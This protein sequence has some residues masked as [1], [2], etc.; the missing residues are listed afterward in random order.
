MSRKKYNRT[1]DVLVVATMS[2]GKT[3]LVN[4]LIGRELLHVANE[5]TTACH[6]RIENRHDA[7]YITGC[8]YS[9]E[10]RLL[11]RQHDVSAIQLREWNSYDEI[12]RISLVGR[13][14][15]DGKLMPGLVLHD[16]PGVN[17]SQDTLHAELTLETI[18][19]VPFKLLVYVINA[20]QLG[21]QDDRNLLEK[22]RAE[23]VERQDST[24]CF[25]L[26][27]I[28]LLD[29]GK[30]ET[31][32]KYVANAR[33]YLVNMGFK[34]PIII[35][36]MASVALYARKALIGESLTRAQD[37]RLQQALDG[38]PTY[39]NS[40]LSYTNIPRCIVKKVSL[41]LRR[42]EKECGRSQLRQRS[43]LENKLQQLLI[44]SGLG[45]LREYIFYMQSKGV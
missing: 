2:A 39:S 16:T 19:K 38:L 45:L 37:I 17:N 43:T 6:I 14:V 5:A 4:A 30:G 25:V 15:S 23:V 22:L 11:G 24:F 9:H 31:L 7:K 42:L 10:N 21:T 41:S 27:K 29:P 3:S 26:N 40:L 1:F 12:K 8:C 32:S 33:A 36:C 13:F 44:C 34:N 18:R 28:D 20:S 35:P